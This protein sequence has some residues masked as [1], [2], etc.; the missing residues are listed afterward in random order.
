MSAEAGHE[1][2]TA[3]EVEALRQGLNVRDLGPRFGLSHA[4]WHAVAGGQRPAGK[5]GRAALTEIAAFLNTSVAHVLS[6]AEVLSPLD[7]LSPAAR[8]QLDESY[9]VL[10]EEAWMRDLLP[11]EAS[12]SEAP[13]DM[14]HA[15]VRMFERLT[16]RHLLDE[17][18]VREVVHG[19]S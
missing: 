15:M 1:L 19:T 7:F 14:R 2:V 18:S 10:A 13:V 3:V 5:L 12:W 4:Y 16:G 9:G 11:S 17:A 8:K 6:L